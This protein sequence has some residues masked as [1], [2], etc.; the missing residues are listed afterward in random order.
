MGNRA[1]YPPERGA[2]GSALHKLGYNINWARFP[3][4]RLV[5]GA[6]F[7]DENYYQAGGLPRHTA[8]SGI[9]T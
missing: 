4:E 9:G 7:A 2:P 3:P 5:L 8:S 6:T 1:R